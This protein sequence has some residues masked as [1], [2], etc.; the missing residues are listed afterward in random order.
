MKQLRFLPVTPDSPALCEAFTSLM[1]PYSDELDDQ[2]EMKP[3]PDMIAKWIESIIRL[4]GNGDPDRHL[5]LCYDGDT[6]IGFLY[7]KVDHPDH[8][9]FIKPGYG[10]VMEFYVRPEFRRQGYATAMNQR[11]EE[12]FRAD[13]ATKTYLT[14]APR[15][16]VP[17][18]LAVG[19]HAT[20]E[21][22][23]DNDLA[24]YEKQL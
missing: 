22:S 10:Y 11:M 6:L 20:G 9:G 7:G 8:R 17:F 21:I 16:G 24:I 14:A 4:Q 2:T 3:T 19:Y 23:P 18:W 15:T 5:D 12:L 13:G 1:F